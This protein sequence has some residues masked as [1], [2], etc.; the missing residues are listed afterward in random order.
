MSG[1]K[2]SRQELYDEIWTIS[3]SK[4]A[5]KYEV[6]YA[7]F[8]KIC[9]E[10]NIPV[11]PSGY[12]TKLQCGKPVEKTPLPASKIDVVELVPE[13]GRPIDTN[14][15]IAQQTA[16]VPEEEKIGLEVQFEGQTQRYNRETLYQEVWAD[17]IT[18]VSKRYGKSDYG[19]R[20]IC[21]KLEVPIPPAG[22]W[23]KVRAGKTVPKPDLPKIK[24]PPIEDKPKTGN[25][26]P[27]HVEDTALSFLKE[28]DRKKIIDAASKLRVAGSGAQLHKDIAAH[29]EKCESWLERHKDWRGRGDPYG[30]EKPLF[31]KDISKQTYPRA[32]HILDALLKGMLPF[33]A[34]VTNQFHFQ[35]NG[36]DVPFAISESKDQIPHEITQAEKMELLKYEEA[37]RKD[38]WAS[39][40]NIPKYDHPWNGRLT[41][42]IIGKYRFTDCK[43]YSLEDRIGEIMIAFYEASYSVRLKRLE[44]EERRRKEEEERRK[45][46]EI[47]QRRNKEIDYTEGLINA[48]EDYNSACRIRAYIAAMR[49][50]G[51]A[52]AEWIEWATAKADWLDPT[53]RAEDP[54]LGV[55]QHEQSEEYKRL[56][57]KGFWY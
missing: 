29:K 57:K 30:D 4:V 54:F 45:A 3:A 2:V 27:L 43:S 42:T 13:K 51:K 19:L 39:K 31:T 7:R 21:R 20:E 44:A 41:I 9:K 48:A 22:Y 23:A 8:L 47:R 10:N 14:E 49:A 36:E 1:I 37:K 12:W 46:E 55:R 18:V 52:S 53:I 6:S 32:Y 56:K 28:D 38:R 50:A 33:G 34:S 35:V 40:P 25:R 16:S 15:I 26:R 24:T 5:T 11:P 17:P